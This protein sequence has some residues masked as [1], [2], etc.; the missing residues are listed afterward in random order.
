MRRVGKPRRLR[1]PS[2]CS[3]RGCSS[4]ASADCSRRCRRVV[5]PSCG[6]SSPSLGLPLLTPPSDLLAALQAGLRER[7][8]AQLVARRA[9]A[10]RQVGAAPVAERVAYK[11]A[12]RELRGIEGAQHELQRL[13]AREVQRREYTEGYAEFVVLDK[14]AGAVVG[15]LVTD[16]DGEREAALERICSFLGQTDETRL[17]VADASRVTVM[18][19]YHGDRGE[20]A[21]PASRLK[22]HVRRESAGEQPAAVLLAELAAAHGRSEFAKLLGV[23]DVMVHSLITAPPTERVVDAPTLSELR[24]QAAERQVATPSLP[25]LGPPLL[26]LLPGLPPQPPLACPVHIHIRPPVSSPLP[27]PAGRPISRPSSS[28]STA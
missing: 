19:S 28:A 8:R 23:D 21:E 11:R 2:R 20:V 5:H 15:A 6:L 24:A 10:F 1:M 13:A 22:V 16:E 17:Y 26:L 18:I 3:P 9:E 14:S 12:S 25:C 7:L 4:K 27:L